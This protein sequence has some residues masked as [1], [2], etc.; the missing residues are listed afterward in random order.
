YFAG[1]VARGTGL[2]LTIHSVSG[3]DAGKYHCV[4]TRFAKQPTRPETGPPIRLIVNASPILL[5]PADHQVNYGSIGDSLSIECRADGVP[6][7]EITWTKNDKIVS[8][9]PQLQ[10]DKLEQQHEGVYTC[11]AV[12]V[13]GRAASHFELKFSKK[14]SFDFVPSNKTVV[15]GSNVFWRCH[16]D[17]PPS[18]IQYSWMFRDRPIKTTETGLR[19][20]I[21]DGDLSLRDVR[22]H[23]GGWYVCM[24]SNPSGEQSQ[25]SAFLDVLCE[26]F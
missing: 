14:P 5:S 16:V 8:T 22:K 13:E 20:E 19:S 11:L 15:E 25:A 21:K 3:D 18:G 7:P 12:N 10:I 1:S 26:F 6:P 2:G 24:A 17:A 23:D 4:V 9:G